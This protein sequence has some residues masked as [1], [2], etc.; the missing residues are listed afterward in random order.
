MS[1]IK[2]D[3]I[4]KIEGHANV[5]VNIEK[6]V[7]KKVQFETVEGARFFEGIVVGRKYYDVQKFVSRICGVCSQAHL[8]GAIFALENAL[9]VK[10][11]KQ[12]RLLRKLVNIAS[13][14]QS[15]TLHAYF[16]ALPD[17]LG[18]ES[19]ISMAAKHGDEVKRALKIKKIANDINATIGGRD[20]HCITL[21][22]GGFTKTPTNDGLKE[23]LLRV[24]EGKAEA[25]KAAKLFGSIKY[26]DFE[27]ETEYLAIKNEKEYALNIGFIASTKGLKVPVEKYGDLIH[28]IIKNYAAS[29]F[30]LLK[31]KGYMVGALSRINNNHGQLSS[32]AKKAIRD[33]RY[34]FPSFNPFLNNFAQA[35][36]LVHLFDE[37]I[38][39]LKNLKIKNEGEPD[40]VDIKLR[41]GHGFAGLEVPRGTL[42]H[43]YELD[44]DGVVTKANIIA[45]TTQNLKN[46]EDDLKEYIPQLI[47]KKLPKNKMIFEIEK[48]IRAYDPCISC[49]THFVRLKNGTKNT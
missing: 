41:P 13:I 36:E 49:S 48:L 32:S 16:L 24:K 43:E 21:V 23:L 12:T 3:H 26:P 44:K 11:S 9:G 10:V 42:F 4:T 28:E 27:R 5:T 30:A 18:F 20:I 8:L 34:D 22:V 33:S 15:H 14:V 31:N 40:L 35:V 45:P 19:A 47:Q 25:T 39:I 7:L 6:G 1:D 29:K 37:A 2:I 46:I 17:Y 38:D